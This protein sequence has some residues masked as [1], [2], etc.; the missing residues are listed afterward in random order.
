M[1]R[2]CGASQQVPP[3]YSAVKVDGRRLHA[4]ARA[5]DE[6]ERAPRPIEVRAFA[7]VSCALPRARFQVDCSKGTYVRVLVA[8]VGQALGCGAHLTALRR[9]RSGAM[10]LDGAVPLDDLTPE[11]AAAALVPIERAV[12]HL[13][14]VQLGA[15][16]A[17]AASTGKPMN[18]QEIS[19]DEAPAG[20][21][22]LFAPGGLLVALAEVDPAFRVRYR[23]VFGN[24][25]T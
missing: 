17:R 18:W 9:T 14:A 15:E 5:G 1:Q 16:Q 3:M 6:V 22:A 11:R 12:R 13:P 24:P 8:D 25:L 21:V 19:Q 23:R 20:T 2:L 10:T 4:I 7:L